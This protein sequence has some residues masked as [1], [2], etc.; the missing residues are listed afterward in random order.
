MSQK[1]SKPKPKARFISLRWRFILPLFIALLPV[2]MVGA[3]VLANNLGGGMAVSQ[4]NILLQ[5]S[6]AVIVPLTSTPH[7]CRRRSAWRSPKAWG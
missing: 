1:T 5:N 3:Y 7:R 2:A 4:E 6:R